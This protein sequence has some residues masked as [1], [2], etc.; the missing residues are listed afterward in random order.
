MKP[1]SFACFCLCAG[2]LV[3][4]I[5]AAPEIDPKAPL[6]AEDLGIA[7]W[8]PKPDGE[9]TECLIV[10]VKITD[11]QT[12]KVELHTSMGVLDLKSAPECYLLT[13]RPSFLGG[14]NHQCKVQ[15]GK[16]AG[17]ST[18][19]TIDLKGRVDQTEGT[20]TPNSKTLVRY[21]NG[22][23]YEVNY[24]VEEI[25]RDE[26]MAL[27]G[28]VPTLPSGLKVGTVTLKEPRKVTP[29]IDVMK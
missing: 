18:T 20:Y 4:P 29:N 26:L 28:E 11:V 2:S 1:S 17:P 22:G 21:L 16:W 7:K 3:A 14:N 24:M 9:K 5:H 27:T 25:S 15:F 19:R 13:Y 6:L 10:T 23:G 8:I 12:D